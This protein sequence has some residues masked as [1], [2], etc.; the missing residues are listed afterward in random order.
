[1]GQTASGRWVHWR[2]ACVILRCANNWLKLKCLAYTLLRVK[3]STELLEQIRLQLPVFL[4]PVGMTGTEAMQANLPSTWAP[5][6][7]ECDHYRHNGLPRSRGRVAY[8]DR[9]LLSRLS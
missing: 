7:S 9:E 4:E 2:T 3:L 5:N 6:P 8:C 1:M